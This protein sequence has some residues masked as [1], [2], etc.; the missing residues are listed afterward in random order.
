[1]KLFILTFA[2]FFPGTSVEPEHPET[3]VLEAETVLRKDLP[4]GFPILMLN[5]DFAILHVKFENRTDSDF[6][7][8]VEQMEIYS[9]KDDLIEKALST[10]VT[11]EIV[12]YYRSKP[13]A[14]YGQRR[15]GSPYPGPYPGSYPG[16]GRVRPFGTPESGGRKVRA[17]IGQEVREVVE[18][19]QL[20][21]V[22]VPPGHYVEGYV[23]LKSKDSGNKLSGGHVRLNELRADF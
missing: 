16:H 21:S 8:N 6:E 18:S 1:M 22:V 14:I 15:Y 11:P 7:L 2:L 4:D 23:Y 10:E 12:K 19:Y 13:N 20:R 5:E 17:T 9:R 3:A